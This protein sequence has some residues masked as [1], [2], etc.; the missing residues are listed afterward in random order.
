[1]TNSRLKAYLKEH[2]YLLDDSFVMGTSEAQDIIR[3]AGHVLSFEEMIADAK[4]RFPQYSAAQWAEFDQTI[5]RAKKNVVRKE[6]LEKQ[7]WQ[8]GK[9]CKAAFA[10]LFVA[11]ILFFAVFPAGRALAKGI[12]D[13]TIRVFENQAEITPQDPVAE[14][15]PD[16]ARGAGSLTAYA[17]INAFEDQTGLKPFLLNADWIRMESI[18]GEYDPDF[19]QTL[20]INYVDQ[21]GNG[22][23]TMQNWLQGQDVHAWT[24]DEA[25]SQIE[26]FEGKTLYYGLD[27]SNQA[28]DGIVISNDS[29]IIIGADNQTETERMINIT[30]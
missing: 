14:M 11:V 29:L 8:Y 28:F 2:P 23:R 16:P 13:Y 18:Q 5:E 6:R 4:K 9:I 1:M 12:Y 26:V 3:S 30:I 25:Y 17:S 20:T 21:N 7:H 24:D 10:G 15:L 27:P 22:I 19:G